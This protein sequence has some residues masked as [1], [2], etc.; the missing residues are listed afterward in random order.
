[1]FVDVVLVRV[2]GGGPTYQSSSLALYT[3]LV[4]PQVVDPL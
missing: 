4:G 2:A 3:S 1:L